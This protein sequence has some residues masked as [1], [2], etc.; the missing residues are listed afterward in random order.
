MSAAVAADSRATAGRA[1]PARCGSPSC[2]RPP[3][4]SIRQ[5]ASIASPVSGDGVGVAA[6]SGGRRAG[7]VPRAEARPSPR[8]PARRCGIPGRRRVRRP[9]S[10]APASPARRWRSAPPRTGGDGLPS[11][12]TMPDF[13][14][15]GATGNTTSARAVTSEVAQLQADDETGGL[16]RGECGVRVG[17]VGRF[18]AADEQRVQLAVRGGVEDGGGVAPGAVRQ[19][20]EVPGVGDL[21]T[22]GGIGDRSAAGQQGGQAAGV[23]RAAL[24][25]PARDP[26]QPGAR[27]R[28]QPAQPPRTLPGWWPA[29][30]RP[31]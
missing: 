27:R 12:G 10:P 23:Q 8:G 30:R 4:S 1:V 24:A 9:A 13:S 2:N 21:L 15:T 11:W 7:A 5:P 28:R 17:Q 25:G 16:D 18:D 22:G 31:G 6:T 26:G 14:V 19:L 3:S 29:A 20:G